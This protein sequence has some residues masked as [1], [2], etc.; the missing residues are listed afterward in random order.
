M[1]SHPE[2]P[3]SNLPLPRRSRAVDWLEWAVLGYGL[4]ANLLF[5]ARALGW[6][7]SAPAWVQSQEFTGL[8]IAIFWL[9]WAASMYV[10]A[11][12]DHDY[13]KAKSLRQRAT[14]LAVVGVP[15]IAMNIYDLTQGAN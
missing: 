7:T 12:L 3:T 10:R 1:A 2:T 11:H 13:S 9:A 5:F 6:L 15:L 8:L 4:V 14:V